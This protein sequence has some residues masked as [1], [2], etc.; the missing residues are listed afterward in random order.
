MK[1]SNFIFSHIIQ[2][3]LLLSFFRNPP[4]S[5]G[6]GIPPPFHNEMKGL[7]K[8]VE[9]LKETEPVVLVLPLA[10]FDH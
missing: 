3:N 10:R 4:V 6:R 2:P 7:K 8:M 9:T 1:A 5:T